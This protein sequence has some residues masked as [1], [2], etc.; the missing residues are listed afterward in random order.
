M[1]AIDLRCLLVGVLGTVAIVAA[2]AAAGDGPA[3]A[4]R[5]RPLVVLGEG[6]DPLAMRAM[7]LEATR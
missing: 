7:R 4:R 2:L 6:H 3:L 5:E 1:T